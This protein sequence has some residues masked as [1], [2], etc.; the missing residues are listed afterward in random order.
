MPGDVLRRSRLAVAHLFLLCIL[1]FLACAAR[2]ETEHGH[3]GGGAGDG[4]AVPGHGHG[5]EHEHDNFFFHRT[6]DFAFAPWQGVR[7]DSD[8]LESMLVSAR[9]A[10]A[11]PNPKLV[12]AR[13][14]NSASARALLRPSFCHTAASTDK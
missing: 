7:I 8:A 3:A 9:D 10:T 1:V 2:G 5:H 13:S 12:G 11:V 4:D 6:L 14:H